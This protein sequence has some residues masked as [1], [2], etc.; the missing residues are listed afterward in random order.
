LFRDCA[1]ILAP[2]ATHVFNIILQSGTPPLLGN[3]L[4]SLLSL[5]FVSQK[6]FKICVLYLLLLFFLDYLN[7]LVVSKFLLP[8]LPKPLFNDQFAFRPTGSTTAALV[9]V[10]HHT[11]RM[12]EEIHMLGVYLLTIQEVLTPSI[13]N[14][15]HHHQLLI[16]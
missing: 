3:V 11:T 6:I 1:G 13:I 10:L 9:H 16:T 14:S 5:K 2:V 8:V 12:L 7:G 4:L 15:P